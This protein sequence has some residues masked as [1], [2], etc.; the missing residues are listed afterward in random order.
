MLSTR[1]HMVCMIAY[2]LQE[3]ENGDKKR[4][5]NSVMKKMLVF[6]AQKF[7]QPQILDQD[8]CWMTS[9]ETSIFG[10]FSLS[11]TG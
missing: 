7:G 3:D 2:I 6:L 11:H 10:S 1:K 5:S 9:E 8:H 4:L